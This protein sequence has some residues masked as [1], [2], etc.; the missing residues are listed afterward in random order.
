MAAKIRIPLAALILLGLLGWGLAQSPAPAV[1]QNVTLVLPAGAKALPPGQH[2]ATIDLAGKPLTARIEVEAPAAAEAARLPG[3]TPPAAAEGA[4]PA[5]A[6]TTA[7]LPASPP[8]PPATPWLLIGMAALVPVLLIVIGALIYFKRIVPRRNLQPYRKAV[9]LLRDARYGDALPLL[10]E[11]EGK[12]SGATRREARFFIAFA[13]GMTGDNDEAERVATALHREDSSDPNAAYLLVWILLRGEKYD[14]AE[15]V[16]E[17]MESGG[18]LGIRDAKRLLGIV[19]FARANE[20]FR[21]GRVDAAAELF[22]KVTQLGDFAEHVPA[23]LRNRHIVLGTQALFEKEVETARKQFQQLETAAGPMSGATAALLRA[24]A[25]LGLALVAW[26]EG[27]SEQAETLLAATAKHFDPEGPLSL[28]WPEEI[29]EV[30]ISAKVMDREKSKAEESGGA[31]AAAA[32]RCLRDIHFMRGMNG[33][34]AWARMDSKEAHACIAEQYQQAL[35]RFACAQARDSSFADV[36]MVVGLL[37][38]YL[39]KP[40]KERDQGVKLLELSRRNKMHEPESLEILHARDKMAKVSADTVTR[41]MEALDHYIGD[42]TVTEAI[43]AALLEHLAAFARYASLEKRPDLRHARSSPPTV[44]EM[45][46]RSENLRKHVGGLSAG[47]SSDAA[48][49]CEI[50]LSL[51][52]ESGR[53]LE[54]A[55]SIEQ[56]ESELLAAAGD[57][58]F[59]DDRI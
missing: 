29:A 28:P 21:N 52:H 15:P 33:L 56:K 47:G 11:V 1:E 35:N 17:R 43:R 37:M 41:Y 23:D 24:K 8:P 7:D 51:E 57:A 27:D 42:D 58:L 45:L 19:K 44:E 9:E 2:R 13:S 3:A 12:L 32:S 54:Q 50:S 26:T 30:P 39:H 40:G 55:H 18:E 22:E 46:R 38:F 20:A 6:A 16:L 34:R 36:Y 4:K 14:R 10:T 48:R 31:E 5:S 53:L 59:R 49:L 25:T